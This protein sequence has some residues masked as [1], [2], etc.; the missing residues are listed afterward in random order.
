[1]K[2]LKRLRET[3]IALLPILV[4]VFFVHFFLY[5]FSNE[6]LIKF[7]VAVVIAA[8]GEALLLMGIDSTIMPMGELMVNSVTK[9]SRFIIFLI[10]AMLF[11][12]FATIAEPDVSIFSSQAVI[13]GATSSKTLLTFLIG[14]GL[15]VLVAFGVLCIIKSINLTKDGLS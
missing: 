7:A 3:F 12:T 11:G 10:F 2:F 4:V 14:A 1:M 8:V 15:G 13:A 9:A 6:V 5:E